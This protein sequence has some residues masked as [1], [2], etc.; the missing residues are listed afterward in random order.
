VRL[1][2]GAGHAL[3]EYPFSAPGDRIPVAEGGEE[4][5]RERFEDFP[6]R[7]VLGDGSML[8]RDRH[9]RREAAGACLVAFIR[10]WR[11]VGGLLGGAEGTLTAHAHDVADRQRGRG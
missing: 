11:I 6:R 2:L 10:E 9:Q 8:R 4:R 1:P 5:P 3:L 7:F